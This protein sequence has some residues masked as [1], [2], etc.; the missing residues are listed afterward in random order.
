MGEDE[1]E[2]EK[3]KEEEDKEEERK[4]KAKKEK[5]NN[6]KRQRDSEKILHLCLAPL[7][8]CHRALQRWNSFVERSF[9]RNQ[10]LWT[11]LGSV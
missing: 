8:C 1:E 5:A 6:D 10:P 3:E 7:H 11:P 9:S 4:K 2:E